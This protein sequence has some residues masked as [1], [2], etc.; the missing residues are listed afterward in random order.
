MTT[1][2]DDSAG[3]EASSPVDVTIVS[4][5]VATS[6]AGS[7]GISASSF[8]TV[9]I[10][11]TSVTTGG[12]NSPGI[13]ANQIERSAGPGTAASARRLRGER[14][15]GGDR[16][17]PGRY[18]NS[19]SRP[20]PATTARALTGTSANGFVADHQRHGQHHRLQFR[21]DHRQRLYRRR[22]RQR[23]RHHHRQ[24]EQRH[25]RRRDDRIHHHHQR[26]GQHRRLQ[27]RRHRRRGGRRRRHHKHLGDD[28][29]L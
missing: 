19:T 24:R 22:D 26:H 23:H 14:P 5:T 21:R 18:V 10:T 12:D 17:R 11:S 7:P 15:G 28:D 16:R 27:F 8:G 6:G 20:R 4:G 2:G 13:S 25:P 1:L 3:I 9:S 29:R